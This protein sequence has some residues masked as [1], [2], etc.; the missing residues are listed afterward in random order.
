MVH[1]L[2][3]LTLALGALLVA[4]PLVSAVDSGALVVVDEVKLDK[5]KV[6]YGDP[7]K[8]DPAQ[9]HKVG[10]VRSTDVY[11]ET[12]QRKTIVREGIKKGTPRYNQLMKEATKSYKAALKK[13]A[14]DKS[15]KLI[16]EDGGISGYS[17]DDVTQAVIDALP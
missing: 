12:D 1:P 16:V 17:V 5:T 15:L 9:D 11:D 14:T 8:F 2:R 4:A 13:V 7:A 6:R 10:T 3:I